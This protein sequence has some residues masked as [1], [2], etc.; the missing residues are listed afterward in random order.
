[1]KCLI[2]FLYRAILALL[3]SVESGFGFREMSFICLILLQVVTGKLSLVTVPSSDH[4]IEPTAHHQYKF[5]I[6]TV[7]RKMKFLLQF[8]EL[9]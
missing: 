5:P 8:A 3:A 4:D 9:K 2:F 7:I 6:G 1:M